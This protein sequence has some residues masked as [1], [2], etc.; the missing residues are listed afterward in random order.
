MCAL[1]SVADEVHCYSACVLFDQ[2]NKNAL[3]IINSVLEVRG[4]S[5]LRGGMCGRVL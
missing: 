2:G 1:L 5:V 3:C 4:V